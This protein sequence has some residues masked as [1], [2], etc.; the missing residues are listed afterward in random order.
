[1]SDSVNT[2]ENEQKAEVV[3]IDVLL[4]S[5]E[6]VL[7]ATADPLSLRA[8]ANLLGVKSGV[9]STLMDRLKERLAGNEHGIDVIE[10]AGGYQFCTKAAHAGIVEKMLKEVKKVRL[11]PAA[12]E[13]LAIISY[14]QPVTRADV[15]A[16]RGVNCDSSMK[17]LLERELLKIVGK[18]DEPGRPLLYG[19][20]EIFLK[21]FGLKNVED[22]PPL[23]EF[24]EIVEA[25]GNELEE[26]EPT[27]WEAVT[28]SQREALDA[29][30]TAAER[31]LSQIDE[32]IAE[33]K[34]RKVVVIEDDSE[35]APSV[36]IDPTNQN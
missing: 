35:S 27:D 23:S 32:K 18:K 22:L 16:I 20:T 15:E 30:S 10:I 4:P 11:S 13:T 2:E 8:L 26:V 33:F 34:P 1:M 36:E 12:L 5:L 28:E 19:T 7:L 14:R 6:A 17:T 29:L 3:N 21:H 24:K 31:E 25:R 9:I